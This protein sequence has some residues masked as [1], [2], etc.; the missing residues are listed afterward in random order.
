METKRETRKR[1]IELRSK[2]NYYEMS[3]KSESIFERLFS[4][5]QYAD[6]VTVLAYMSYRNEVLTRPFIKRCM[7]DGKKIAVPKVEVDKATLAPYGI[8]SLYEIKDLE[9]DVHTGFKGIPEPNSPGLRKVEPQEIDLVVVPGVAFDL[10]RNR[11]GYGAGHYDKLLPLL[12]PDCL[13]V[14]VAYEM[15]LT[16]YIAPS[17]HDI[18]MDMVITEQRVV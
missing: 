10:S 4:M 1:I 7:R 11:I 17:A 15:Q 5:N 14:A 13:K 2:L 16:E 6:A 12:R 18:A 8:L 3:E 9:N